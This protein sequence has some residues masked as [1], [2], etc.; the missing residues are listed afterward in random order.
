MNLEKL[1]EIFLI[2]QR[3]D[4]NGLWLEWFEEIKNN[5]SSFDK[6]YVISVLNEWH[7]DTKEVIYSALIDI[8]KSI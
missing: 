5:E 4:P 1:S 8:V 6:E 7:K 3:H 2:M